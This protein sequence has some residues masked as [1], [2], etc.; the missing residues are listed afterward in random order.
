MV[1]RSA[2]GRTKARDGYSAALPAAPADD[3]GDA[4]GSEPGRAP[5]DCLADETHSI[6]V[7]GRNS[8][9]IAADRLDDLDD[10]TRV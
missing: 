4:S 5:R 3:G 8:W 1:R 7:G 10:L 6:D 2:N 9:V